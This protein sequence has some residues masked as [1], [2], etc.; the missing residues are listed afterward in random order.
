MTVLGWSVHWYGV[1]IMLGVLLGGLLGAAREKSLGLPAETSLD[2]VLLGVPAALI[3]ARTYYVL[4]SL[5]QFA[6][7]PWWKAFALWEGGMAIYG[8]L[9]G[10]ILA[11]WLYGRAK[12]LPT[13]K[14]LDLAAPCFALGQ[15]VG[16]WGNFLNQEAHGGMVE[17]PA[18]RF[19]PV[20][21][22]IGGEWYYATFFYESM[23]CLL[24]VAAIL[25]AER[26]K[27]LK[28]SGDGFML[29][30]FL[31]ALERAVVEGMRT[32][33]LMLGGLRVSQG[34][35]LLAALAATVIWAAR[36]G[37]APLGLRLIAPA[38]VLAAIAFAA[39]GYGW[40]TLAAAVAAIPAAGA[41]Y[42]WNIS[43]YNT[44]DRG[45]RL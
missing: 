44:E 15:A 3:G 12:K 21:V 10:G 24:I 8:A 4:F 16:R 40:G 20:A 1:L 45:E 23:W 22:E 30:A 43:T 11:G 25:F 19:F 14:L 37:R 5:D 41:V 39:A 28:R 32:D 18:L 27:L 35:S 34:L 31:Y 17:N 6:G 13:P 9:L 26:R 29:Y 2:L 7:R 42:R 33:S 38:C 36:A